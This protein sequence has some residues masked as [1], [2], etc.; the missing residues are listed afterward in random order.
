ADGLQCD[1][2]LTSVVDSWAAQ[3]VIRQAREAARK[4]LQL[5]AE[6]YLK[7]Q[8]G[9]WKCRDQE[10]EGHLLEVAAQRIDIR[11]SRHRMG[12]FNDT[13]I[14]CPFFRIIE[15]DGTKRRATLFE[16]WEWIEK[17]E[18]PA[19]FRT[20][21]EWVEVEEWDRP[22]VILAEK[23]HSDTL[24]K[25]FGDK[26]FHSGKALARRL[27]QFKQAGPYVP[28]CDGDF[29]G[30]FEVDGQ[31][32]N[33]N[34][35]LD[36]GPGKVVGLRGGAVYFKD[37]IPNLPNGLTVYGE[38]QWKPDFLGHLEKTLQKRV[39]RGA[40]DGIAR[41]L[42]AVKPLPSS[43]DL[44]AATLL[45]R[46]L[47]PDQEAWTELEADRLDWLWVSSHENPRMSP[48]NYR[49]L[50]EQG[51]LAFYYSPFRSAVE[52]GEKAS[53]PVH[54]LVD[55]GTP[56]FLP[57][58]FQDVRG[59]ERLEAKQPFDPNSLEDWHLISVESLGFERAVPG[60][61]EVV[62]AFPPRNVKASGVV[63]E[64]NLRGHKLQ[65][66]PVSTFVGPAVIC[67]EL[68]QGWPDSQ[69]RHLVHKEQMESLKALVP[70]I[71]TQAGRS[72]WKEAS[73]QLL[74]RLHEEVQ[75]TV[76]V[77][78]WSEGEGD[79]EKRVL[80]ANGDRVSIDELRSRSKILYFSDWSR[81]PEVPAEAIYLTGVQ[82][83]ALTM[84]T[85]PEVWVNV[86]DDSRRD[87]S[88][89]LDSP[90]PVARKPEPKPKPKPKLEPQRPVPMPAAKAPPG[91]ERKPR[92]SATLKP[93]RKAKP[94]PSPVPDPE[95]PE[96][97]KP[98]SLPLSVGDHSE[99]GTTV[100]LLRGIFS[101]LQRSHSLPFGTEFETFLS[102]LGE[103]AGPGPLLQESDGRLS[104]RALKSPTPE[105]LLA[106]LSALYSQFNHSREH[107]EDSHE[108][109]FHLALVQYAGRESS[110]SV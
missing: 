82:M 6:H 72:L 80:T 12:A 17:G 49:R 10:M 45:F 101:E 71:L 66:R 88:G 89:T 25:I 87:T 109:V 27:S 52:R 51:E 83:E 57:P 30:R 47:G 100:R 73:V 64:I 98:A 68:S 60:V 48:E 7:I 5:T 35:E 69:G 58:E 103:N 42:S 94:D 78:I 18:N 59:L 107:I 21:E 11:R 77:D 92:P 4:A 19:L 67:L 105:Q 81:A 93:L 97:V 84:A 33:W 13:L 20:R 63:L 61:G 79:R 37:F 26:A 24:L 56:R 32:L 99:T 104:L 102:S 46:S 39:I 85:Q 50:V 15:P 44:R 41:A 96:P 2:G 76:L 3:K 36:G 54:L 70:E 62:V 28:P 110:S 90:P 91:P 43:A 74:E 31:F 34:L 14:R 8:L 22:V 65:S 9:V 23:A 108:Q 86:L 95:T 53:W 1:L 75:S 16:I 106:I 29:Q 40:L 38:V 55:E